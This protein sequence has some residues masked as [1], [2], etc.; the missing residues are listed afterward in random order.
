MTEPTREQIATA[1]RTVR[2]RL[3]PNAI[4][5]AQRGE[6]IMLSLGEADDIADAVLA[7]LPAPVDRAAALTEAERTMLAYALDQA[8]ERIWSEGGFTAEDQAAVTSLRRL[9]AETATGPAAEAH[10]D[11][12]DDGGAHEPLHRWRVEILDGKTWISDS[13]TFGARSV[14]QDRYRAATENAPAW[15]DGQ[16]MR[17]RLVR[18]TTT[19]A[20]EEPVVSS[21][22]GSAA[23]RHDEEARVVAYL[24]PAGVGLHCLRCAPKP[25]GD[26]WTPVTAE[27][28]DTG[29]ICLVCHVD[30]LI[31]QEPGRDA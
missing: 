17:R 22:V 29:G 12:Q 15:A 27:E 11:T 6:Q 18:E 3:G 13:R 8:Q 30:V 23:P 20:V 24:P 26:I 5:A 2:L 7:V 31:P 9:V 10:T 14:A 28:L 25:A 21:S 16:P 19:F 1:A 4:A